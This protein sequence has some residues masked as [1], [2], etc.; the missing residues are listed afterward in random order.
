MSRAE[1]VAAATWA[2]LSLE[3]VYKRSA[4]YI[5]TQGVHFGLAVA[6]LWPCLW[7]FFGFFFGI[8]LGL[9]LVWHGLDLALAW[10]GLWLGLAFGLDLALALGFVLP[11]AWTLAL[12]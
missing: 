2:L 6:W 3:V 11:L 7:L 10:L 9:S 1:V 4:A 8:G 5:S 12:V